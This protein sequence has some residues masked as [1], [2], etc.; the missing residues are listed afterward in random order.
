[1]T[2]TALHL[3]VPPGRRSVPDRPGTPRESYLRIDKLMDTARRAAARRHPG[4]TGFS[5]NPAFAQ[6]CAEN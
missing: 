4:L 3:H 5:R 2:P 1:M 6:A